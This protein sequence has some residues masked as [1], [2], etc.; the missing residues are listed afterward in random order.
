MPACPFC[1]FPNPEN[2]SVCSNC[3]RELSPGSRRQR[4]PLLGMKLGAL[5]LQRV[6]VAH[7]SPFVPA[8]PLII[9]SLLVLF[10]VILLSFLR[11][12]PGRSFPPLATPSPRSIAN[13]SPTPS[14]TPT[15]TFTPT[16]T[17]TLSLVVSPTSINANTDCNYSP[18]SGWDCSV[19]LSSASSNQASLIW[20]VSSSGL[21]ASYSQSTGTL[22]P[23]RSQ[24]IE[25]FVS[26][27]TVCPTTGTFT[28]T[29][30]SSPATVSWSCAAPTL[31]VK[32]TSFYVVDDCKSSDGGNTF[33]CALTLISSSSNQGSLNW[34]VSNSGNGGIT[35]SQPN[36]TLYPSNQVGVT[37]TVIVAD[38][39][40]TTSTLSYSESGSN[41][42]NVAWSC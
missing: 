16:P 1:T 6:L 25:I 30:G 34:S 28:F 32:P 2:A 36:G 21:S 17:P 33:M 12:P 27:Q 13:P 7:R 11:P 40:S 29:G 24:K 26:S 39:A 5:A 3:G 22:S 10:N 41:P 15:P 42:I 37:I 38:C 23:G 8:A 35:F 19:T 14:P 31:S 9:V 20:S 18:K 4:S